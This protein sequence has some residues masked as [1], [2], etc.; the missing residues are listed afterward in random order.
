[1]AMVNNNF[2]RLTIVTGS[3]VY[4]LSMFFSFVDF[5]ILLWI[6]T[7]RKRVWALLCRPYAYSK[8]NIFFSFESLPLLERETKIELL[9]LKVYPFS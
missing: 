8:G 4:Y 7:S 6:L 2:K 1:M 9:P 5:F 3:N